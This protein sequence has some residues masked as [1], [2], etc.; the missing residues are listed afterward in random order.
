MLKPS[1]KDRDKM[2]YLYSQIMGAPRPHICEFLIENDAVFNAIRK[3][4]FKC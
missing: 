1:D 3:N 4:K 2:D